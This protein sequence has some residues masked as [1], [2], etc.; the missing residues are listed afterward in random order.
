MG[1]VAMPSALMDRVS[2]LDTAAAS[3]YA[4]KI[5]DGSIAQHAKDFCAEAK[6]LCDADVNLVDPTLDISLKNLL[7]GGNLLERAKAI[8][9][10]SQ[11]MFFGV[12]D[13]VVGKDIKMPA[14]LHDQYPTTSFLPE[15][16]AQRLM[17]LSDDRVAELLQKLNIPPNSNLAVMMSRTLAQCQAKAPVKAQPSAMKTA[18]KEFSGKCVTSME[19]MSKFVADRFPQDSRVFA[20]ERTIPATTGKSFCSTLF[21][22]CKTVAGSGL[23]TLKSPL[24]NQ[25][26]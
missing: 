12:K 14:A 25:Y 11:A 13:L 9:D 20:L 10:A 17:P 8:V 19:D 22:R 1:R 26:C 6:L 4:A 2:P 16:L 21:A 3:S 24:S 18:E 5:E 23:C 7:D 15:S